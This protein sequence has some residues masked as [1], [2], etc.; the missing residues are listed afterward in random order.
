[1]FGSYWNWPE[2]LARLQAAYDY[3]VSVGNSS[4]AAYLLSLIAALR[5]LLGV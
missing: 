5:R 4:L 2:T 1:M 3:A